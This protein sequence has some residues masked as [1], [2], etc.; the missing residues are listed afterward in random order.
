LLGVTISSSSRFS[1]S[2][3]ISIDTVPTVINNWLGRLGLQSAQLF[4]AATPNTWKASIVRK[5]AMRAAFEFFCAQARTAINAC[6]RRDAYYQRKS[7][8]MGAA[9]ASQRIRHPG[10][11]SASD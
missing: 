11:T 8:K 7:R 5:S 1:R 10:S 3:A 4:A 6:S 9:A 2:A